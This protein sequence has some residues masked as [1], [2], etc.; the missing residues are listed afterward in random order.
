MARSR[1]ILPLGLTAVLTLVSCL[2]RPFRLSVHDVNEDAPQERAVILI[3]DPQIYSREALVEDRR[4]E[5]KYLTEQLAASKQAQF[6]PEIRRQLQLV[7][8]FMGQV[9]A[10]YDPLGGGAAKDA[11]AVEALQ[12]DIQIARLQAELIAAQQQVANVQAGGDLPVATGN[13][14]VPDPAPLGN[15]SF[16]SPGLKGTEA[17]ESRLLQLHEKLAKLE[18]KAK[19]ETRAAATAASPRDIYRDR[20]AYRAE[21]RSDIDAIRLDDVHDQDGNSLYRLQFRATLLPGEKKDK[22]GVAR[23]TVVPPDLRWRDIDRLY[24]K[25]LGHVTYRLNAER[26]MTPLRA[27]SKTSIFFASIPIGYALDERDDATCSVKPKQNDRCAMFSLAIPP[28][29]QD[30]FTQL[31][32]WRKTPSSST[33]APSRVGWLYPPE[34]NSTEAEWETYE[35]NCKALRDEVR[36]SSHYEIASAS[37]DGYLQRLTIGRDSKRLEGVHRR[38]DKSRLSAPEKL[39]LYRAED[40]EAQLHN[41]ASILADADRGTAAPDESSSIALTPWPFAQSIAEVCEGRSEDGQVVSCQGPW[42]KRTRTRDDWFRNYEPDEAPGPSTWAIGMPGGSARVYAAN[43]VELAQRTSQISDVSDAVQMAG[44]MSMVLPGQGVGLDAAAAQLDYA[45]GQAEAMDRNPVV[46]GF[47]DREADWTGNR[48]GKAVPPGSRGIWPR[49]GW[50]FG[51]RAHIE[52]SG[53]TSDLKLRQTVV[54]HAVTADLSVPGWWPW[55]GLEVETAWIANWHDDCCGEEPD[56]LWTYDE[57]DPSARSRLRTVAVRLP[58]NRADLDGLSDIVLQETG[59]AARGARI[60]QVIPASVPACSGKTTFLI[61]GRDMWRSTDAFLSGLPMEAEGARVLP[62]MEGI[63]VTFDI[64]KISLPRASEDV[65]LT[66]A[67][68]NGT[69]ESTVKIK[70]LNTKTSCEPKPS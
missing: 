21:L 33:P 6:T 40:R 45:A 56:V 57:E 59:R 50:V 58:L 65:V 52:H 18:E 60:E 41:C 16:D 3:S 8:T 15:A 1:L 5:L 19:T 14:V 13:S 24:R 12:R 29:T 32:A 44:A 34:P 10:K 11:G 69:D 26:G 31:L 39:F 51:P 68:R 22:F 28:G 48:L 27:M 55:I 61:Y 35:K 63:A 62:D 46:V 67:T 49:F 43:P 70:G 36:N 7:T 30:E 38:I 66:V 64:N 20:K 17:I 25:W 42:F 53:R 54:N 23:L 2:D 4:T 47:A 9:E 37:L